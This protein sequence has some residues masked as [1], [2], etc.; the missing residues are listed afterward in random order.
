MSR[1][2]PPIISTPSFFLND[3]LDVSQETIIEEGILAPADDSLAF[4]ADTSAAGG[5]MAVSSA[6]KTEKKRRRPALASSRT[7]KGAADSSSHVPGRSAP[8]VDLSRKTTPSDSS[9]KRQS[10]SIPSSTV[11]SNS[12]T[13]TV[14]AL[15]AR[16]KELEQKLAE[17]CHITQPGEDILI[18]HDD[19]EADPAP[20]KGTVSKTRFFGQSHWMNGI[21]MFPNVLDVLKLPNERNKEPHLVFAKCKTLA[22]IIKSHRLKPISTDKLGYT[23]PERGLA[24]QLVNAYFATFEGALRILHGPTFWAEY[25]RYWQNPEA[26]SQV[27]VMQLQT[28]MAIGATVHDDVFSLRSA[29][30]QWIH[31]V[32]IWLQLPP[33]KSRMTIAGIQIM[34]ML[35]LAKGCC[36]VGQEL[37]W[38]TAGALVRQAMYMGLHRDPKHL[39][40]M[41]EYRSEIRRR[42]WITIL[43]L[44]LQSSYDAGGPPLLSSKHYDTRLPAN[45]NDN[46]LSDEPDAERQPTGDPGA[47]TDMSVQLALQKSYALRLVIIKHVNEF[48]S[49]ESYTETLRLNSELTKACRTLTETLAAL[50]QAQRHQPRIIFTQ[51][52]SALVQMFT[53]RCFL[54]LHQPMVARSNDD[55]TYYYSRKVSLDSS[56]K[57]AQLCTLST[58]RYGTYPPGGSNDPATSLNRL[59]TNGSGLFRVVPTLT[60]FSVALEFIKK[61]EEQRDSLGGLPTMGYGELRSVLNAAQIWYERRVLAG[62]TNVKG[63]CF[64]G[65]SIALADAMELGLSQEDIDQTVIDAGARMGNKS[66]ELLKQA[67]ERE[68][69]PVVEPEDE[70]VIQIDVPLLDGDAMQGIMDI[71]LDWMVM[72]DLGLDGMGGFNWARGN[73]PQEFESVDPSVVS[74][75]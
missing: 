47:L 52:H 75:F 41:S 53:Y 45:L 10:S 54:S 6:A 7:K 68:G 5:A 38:V 46:E 48:R 37:T 50:S 24:D 65:A 13:S 42:L 39:A 20:M 1:N 62:E 60:L 15:A 25:E 11:G 36:G 12:E 57:L 73:M 30:T 64:V 16:V 69:I 44:N 32:Q 35:S 34:C 70:E 67:A 28:C 19:Q 2:S 49:K 4:S 74:Q 3:P 58:P 71:P 22:R 63:Y 23:I 29:A 43:E 18:Q 14:D 21:V 40:N 72:G 33:E 59:I 61:C 26:A 55:P 8:V 31:E 56:L 66:Y 27:F 17:S 9:A 51:F